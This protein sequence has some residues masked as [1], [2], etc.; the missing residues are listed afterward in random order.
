MVTGLTAGIQSDPEPVA[1][2]VSLSPGENQITKSD[3][4]LW[5]WIGRVTVEPGVP[6]TNIPFL[7]EGLK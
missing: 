6:M 1:R 3:V 7:S 5:A 2:Y 4:F